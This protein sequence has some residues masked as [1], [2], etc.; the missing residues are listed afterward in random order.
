[1]WTGIIKGT[2]TSTIMHPTM[3]KG[4]LLIVQPIHAI[5]GQAEGLA[6]IAVD[7]LGAGVGQRVLVSSDGPSAQKM[8]Q[9]DRTCPVRLAVVAILQDASVHSRNGAAHKTNQSS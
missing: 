8:L 6:Q 1:M 3:H 2:V 4:K 5:T 7:V 9:T